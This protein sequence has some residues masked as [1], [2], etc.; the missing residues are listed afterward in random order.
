MEGSL[1]SISAPTPQTLGSLTYDF[2]SWCDGGARIHDITA[3]RPGHLH[4]HL[5]GSLKGRSRQAGPSPCN[6]RARLL[7]SQA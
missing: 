4:G 1:N 2:G 3:P 5:R 7:I 6:G